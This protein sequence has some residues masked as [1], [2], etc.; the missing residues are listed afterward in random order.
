MPGV[1]G[2]A[3]P[4]RDEDRV[5]VERLDAGQVDLVVAAH[6]GIGAELAQVLDEVVGERV[7]VVDRRARGPARVRC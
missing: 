3:R 2:G 4:G 1:V 6:D 5:G 7:V